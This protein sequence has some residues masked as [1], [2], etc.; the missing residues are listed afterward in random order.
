LSQDIQ[1]SQMMGGIKARLATMRTR[2]H[3]EDEF[4]LAEAEYF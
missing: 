3:D 2:M 1:F 4:L